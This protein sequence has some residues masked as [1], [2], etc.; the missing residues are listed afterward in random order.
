VTSH[1]E[2]KAGEAEQL[3]RNAAPVFEQQKKAG[4]ASVCAAAL[5]RTLTAKCPTGRAQWQRSIC[6]PV[7]RAVGLTLTPLPGAL[8]QLK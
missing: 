6:Q 7:N 5:A 1:I 3:A 8:D 2:G 4:D